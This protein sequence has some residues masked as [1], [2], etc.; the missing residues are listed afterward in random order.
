MPQ[1]SLLSDKALRCSRLTEE[2][3][4]TDAWMAPVA[5]E[6]LNCTNLVVDLGGTF[7]GLDFDCLLEDISDLI[8]LDALGPAVKGAGNVDL[9][10][11]LVPVVSGLVSQC[12]KNCIPEKPDAS[13][14]TA[15]I[16]RR[17]DSGCANPDPAAICHVAR[18]RLGLS[19]SS[20]P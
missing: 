4:E 11:G 10:G 6:I 9:L 17:L 12:L 16:K 13:G 18:G 8:Q 7:G 3:E 5:K 19:Q 1:R 14:T 2:R 20:R 15:S